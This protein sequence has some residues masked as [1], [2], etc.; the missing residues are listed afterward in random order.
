MLFHVCEMPVAAPHSQQKCCSA[1]QQLVSV[2][3]MLGS[4]QDDAPCKPMIARRGVVLV[5]RW[6]LDSW[7]R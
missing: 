1:A 4:A 3:V 2:A 6:D 7:Q 5:N